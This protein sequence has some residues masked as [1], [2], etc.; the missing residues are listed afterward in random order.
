[1]VYLALQVRQSNKQAFRQN[2]IAHNNSRQADRR[3]INAAFLAIG[4]DPELCRLLRIGLN[5]LQA[6]TKDEKNRLN[7]FLSTLAV[8]LTSP[9]L[10]ELHGPDPMV[11]VR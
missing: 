6:L 8:S 4:E 7:I 9:S 1:L 5:D 11:L 3:E 10:E 2:A